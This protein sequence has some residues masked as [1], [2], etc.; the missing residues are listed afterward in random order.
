[1]AILGYMCRY[2]RVES[3]AEMAEALWATG[4]FT[5][6]EQ[7][8]RAAK[9]LVRKELAFIC[10]QTATGANCY[11]PTAKGILEVSA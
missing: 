11:L 3:G 9:Q 5:S 2:A 1:M 6:L 4:L 10:G 8:Q 7:G